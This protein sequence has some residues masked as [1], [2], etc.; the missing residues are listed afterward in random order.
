M[1]QLA[2]ACIL[3]G[4]ALASAQPK[5]TDAEAWR[6]KLQPHMTMRQVQFLLGDPVDREVSTIAQVWYCE[7]GPVRE[8]G[9][10]VERPTT[11][12]VRFHLVKLDPVTKRRLRQPVFVVGKF[13][14]PDWS[15]VP[16]QVFETRAESIQKKNQEAALERQQAFEQQQ[17]E[18]TRQREDLAKQQQERREATRKQQEELLEK[19][20]QETQARMEGMKAADL[21][22]PKNYSMVYWAVAGGLFIG[23]AVMIAVFK[24]DSV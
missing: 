20:R 8:G 16:E 4:A 19:R 14:E 21:E 18:M 9:K 13:A 10:V 11:G 1:K 23:V 3:L 6:L 12:F 7:K 5:W 15:N 17:Q 2:L 22:E 24:K